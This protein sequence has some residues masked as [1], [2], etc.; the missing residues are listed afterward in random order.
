VHVAEASGLPRLFA[1]LREDGKEDRRKNRDDRYHNKQLDEGK[2]P[3]PLGRH[4]PSPFVARPPRPGGSPTASVAARHERRRARAPHVNVR[5]PW[6]K[7]CSLLA[8]RGGSGIGV[9][10]TA[11]FARDAEKGRR[12]RRE[13]PL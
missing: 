6:R 7:S 1:R 2:S 11:R 13:K 3:L 5:E 9:L 4:R 12:G 10:F 8:V